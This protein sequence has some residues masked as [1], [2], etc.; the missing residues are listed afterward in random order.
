MLGLQWRIYRGQQRLEAKLEESRRKQDDAQRAEST[1]PAPEE[2]AEEP[3]MPPSKPIPEKPDD[4]VKRAPCRMFP[5]G[6][7]VEINGGCYI[8]TD[9]KPPCPSDLYTYQDG[10]YVPRGAPKPKPSAKKNEAPPSGTPSL[11]R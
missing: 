5:R 9:F 4:G 2:A 11:R 7:E 6:S 10:C 3:S 8:K 1:A